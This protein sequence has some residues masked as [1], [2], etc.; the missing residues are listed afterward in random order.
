MKITLLLCCLIITLF[1]PALA[2]NRVTQSVENSRN[3]NSLKQYSSVFSASG[4][5]VN[6]NALTT[7]N[8]AITLMANQKQLQQIEADKSG[9]VSFEIPAQEPVT[10]ELVP[11][12][13]FAPGYK[14]LNAYN[15]EIPVHKGVHYKGII[16]GE[17]NSL[18]A[19]SVIDG[20]M[21]GFISNPKG[22]FVLGK[23][24]NSPQ[25][26]YYKDSDLNQKPDFA[27]DITDDA[28]KHS[29]IENASQAINNAAVACRA[30]NIY[31]EADNNLYRLQYANID[32]TAA[33]TNRQ[34]AQVAVLYSN[35]NIEIQLSGLKV[36][37]TLDPY[38]YAQGTSGM[39]STFNTMLGSNFEGDIAHLLSSRAV[40][41]GMAYVDVLCTKGKG[42]SGNISKW[43]SNLPAFSW[44]TY[45]IAHE[46]GHNFGSRH[47]QSCSWPG[48]PIDNCASP[49][50][51]CAM[52]PFPVNG[53]TIMSY[54]HLNTGINFSNGFGP[55]PG[56]LIRNRAQQCM[57]STSAPIG[58]AIVETYSNSVTLKWS[59]DF[60]QSFIFEFKPLASADWSVFNTTENYI[61][62]SG[63]TANTHYEWRVKVA[64]SAYA[65]STF[66]T[67]NT[68]SVAYCM[69]KFTDGCSYYWI[70]INDFIVDGVNYNPSSGCSSGGMS[71][72]ATS[73]QTLA[74]GQTYNF[75]L[76]LLLANG[77][78]V[79]AAVWIDLNKD[80]SFDANEKVFTT[81]E[82]T[83]QH[84][85]GT[86]SIPRGIVPVARTRM[87]VILNFK[88]APTDPCGEYTWGETEEYFINIISNGPCQQDVAL[89]APNNNMLSGI[90]T[91]QAAAANGHISASNVVSGNSTKI[92]FQARTIELNNGFLAD[93]G[94]VFKAESGG[95]MY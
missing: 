28:P 87:R 40:G 35:E 74:I 55:L 80:G 71:L 95:C 83:R 45:V 22:N 38:A 30:V 79:Q 84:I 43:V 25:Y 27:C 5:K 15:E 70:G 78:E 56:N 77:K 2:Q 9:F 65:S 66:S 21:S 54:C 51:T 62:L 93:V 72:L 58:L 36:W 18:A 19:I 63:L 85:S 11:I 60:S 6:S 8:S 69:P 68:P 3:Q 94:T 7:A 88:Y 44:N 20:E 47:T 34:F 10:L 4:I 26:I 41:G 12:D 49:E 53:G 48:G 67:N 13:I 46:I 64:C 59:H 57:G 50:G 14:V 32:S 82:E 52:G 37:N 61:Q 92:T 31:F 33:F 86:F 81:T 90:N 16:K 24:Q 42:V 75:T 73:T 89:L 23:L 39:L 1:C 76:N 17:P 29:M 91:I